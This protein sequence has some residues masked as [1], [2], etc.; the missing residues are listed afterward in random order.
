MT[1]STA[2][3]SSETAVPPLQAHSEEVRQGQKVTYYDHVR[4]INLSLLKT[5]ASVY[6]YVVSMLL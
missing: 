5:V 3:S 4:H 2:Q 1:E 6:N